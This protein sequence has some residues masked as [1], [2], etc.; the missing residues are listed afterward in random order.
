MDA[1]P[2]SANHLLAS[3]PSQDFGFLRAHLKTIELVQETVLVA[4]GDRLKRVFFPHSG[5]I[6]LVV[7]LAAGGMVEV[8]MIGRD[9]VF[10]GTAALDGS[11]SLTDAIVQLP[12]WASTLDVEIALRKKVSLSAPRSFDINRHFLRRHSSLLHAMPR[13]PPRDDRHAGYCACTIG[14]KVTSCI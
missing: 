10:G 3:L 8:A 12:G 13:M 11:I 4:A 9:S 2:H 7:S 5:V 14:R 1:I 6:S